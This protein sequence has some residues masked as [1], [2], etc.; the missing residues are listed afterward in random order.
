MAAQVRRPCDHPECDGA[1]DYR[2]PKSRNHLTDYYWFC[3]DHVRDY[4]RAWNYYA[5]LSP[6]EIEAATRLDTVWQR[7][8]WP[9]GSWRREELLRERIWTD[10][11]TGD[12]IHG[13]TG[14]HEDATR[15]RV[16]D[17][18]ATQEE[19]ALATLDLT[20]PVGFEQIKRRYK[21]LVKLH[22]PDANGGS[23]EAE[24]RLK[25]INQAYTVLKAA[26][27]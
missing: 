1:G 10:F 2:A 26:Y 5:G 8:T 24:E 19:K 7:P 13:R 22:H 11:A 20:P 14:E 3:L 6:E 4:N 15:Q 9:L 16:R 25:L 12:R 21:A 27:G 18:M 17:R 23:R